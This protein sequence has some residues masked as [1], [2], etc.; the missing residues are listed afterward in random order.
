MHQPPAADAGGLHALV[1]LVAVECA[2]RG[3]ALLSV[4]HRAYTAHQPR[5][6]R[7]HGEVSGRVGRASQE[8]C[9]EFQVRGGL[10]QQGHRAR[11]LPAGCRHGAFHALAESDV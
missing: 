11:H 1:G 8:A 9:A 6:F 2:R 10:F 5:V 7:G 4:H 3:V